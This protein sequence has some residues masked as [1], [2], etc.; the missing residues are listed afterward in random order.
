M[1]IARI[2]YQLNQIIKVT[3]TTSGTNWHNVPSDL[4]HQGHDVT[5]VVFLPNTR[6]SN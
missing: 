2:R 5:G 4:V 6:N 3:I 1:Q